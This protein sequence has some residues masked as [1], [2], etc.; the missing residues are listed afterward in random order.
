MV[1]T[2]LILGKC[3]NDLWPDLREEGNTCEMLNSII[4]FFSWLCPFKELLLFISVV[5]K[6]ISCLCCSLGR[7]QRH[8]PSVSYAAITSLRQYVVGSSQ[9][10]VGGAVFY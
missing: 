9:E 4:G 6:F 8:T 3:V 7:E 1:V 5:R 2:N 10:E